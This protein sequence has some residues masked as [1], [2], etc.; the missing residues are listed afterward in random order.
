MATQSKDRMTRLIESTTLNGVDYIMVEDDDPDAIVLRVHFLNGT[1]LAG[2]AHRV[3]I[4]GGVSIPTVAAMRIRREDWRREHNGRPSLAVRV[5]RRTPFDLSTYTLTLTGDQ[6]DPFFASAPFTF[7]PDDGGGGRRKP[8]ARVPPEAP[9]PIVDYLAKDYRSF[10]QALSDFSALRYPEWQEQS[11]ADFGV[12]FMEALSG[13]ADDLSYTQDRIAAEAYLE[14]ATQRRSLVRLARMVDYEPGTWI[15]SRVD[16]RLEVKSSAYLAAG[17][18]MTGNLPDGTVIPF[19]TG[20]GIRDTSRYLVKNVWNRIPAYYWD[21]RRTILPA[22]ATEMW[23]AG[24]E[25]GLYPGQRLLIETKPVNVGDSPIREIITLAWVRE[26]Q[27]DLYNEQITHIAWGSDCALQWDHDLTTTAVNGNLVPATQGTTVTD[28]FTIGYQRGQPTA[29]AR[30]G[31]NS[32]PDAP[33]A[34]YL[35]SVSQAPVAWLPSDGGE[36][37]PMPELLLTR[38]DVSPHEPWNWALTLC[39]AGGSPRVFTLDQ[40]HYSQAGSMTLPRGDVQPIL[41]YDGDHGD[42]IRFGDDT[43]GAIPER[44]A[45]FQVTYRTGGGAAGNVAPDTITS[46]A[47]VLDLAVVESVTNPFAATGGQDHESKD[48][49]RM[50]APYEYR[51]TPMVCVQA[52]DYEAAAKSLDWV[53]D[54]R[55]SQRWTGSWFAFETSI[56]PRS[57]ETLTMMERAAATRLLNGRRLA[58]YDSFVRNPHP[59]YYDLRIEVNALPGAYRDAVRSAVLA[60]LRP[61]PPSSGA[62]GFFWFDNF[63]FGTPLERSRLEAA[64]Q[65]V[66]GVAGVVSIEYRRSGTSQAYRDLPPTITLESNA[67]LRIDG[68]RTKPSNGLIDVVVGGGQ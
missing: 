31:A 4:E 22:G 55:T 2:S 8:G 9:P 10:R 56:D 12:M 58:G 67:I 45:A 68:D 54:A 19:E 25:L 53:I 39:W 26:E 38:T 42:T 47:P 33:V 64:I 46:F 60:A 61:T 28:S 40:A 3:R 20:T 63:K 15:A 49:I 41:D 65:G 37:Q 6:V 32:R 29:I 1:D 35:Y 11:E 43:L 44:G 51:T 66:S 52:E 14:T 62:T 23:L 5:L 57:T 17:L 16:L 50:A 13:I 24:R 27:D 59:V 7:D 30:L 36:A 34:Q 48:H 21:D 18:P